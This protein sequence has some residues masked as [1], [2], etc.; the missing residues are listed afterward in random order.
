MKKIIQKSSIIFSFV[1]ML[2][3]GMLLQSTNQNIQI[4]NAENTIPIY[5]VY[6]PNSGEHLHTMNWNEKVALVESGWQYEGISMRVG[7]SGQNLY[8]LYNPNSGEHLYT[9][10]W[11]E[12]ENLASKGWKYEGVAWHTPWTGEPVYRAYNPNARNAGTHHYTVSQAEILS[13]SKAGWKNEGIVWYSYGGTVAATPTQKILN[14]PYVSQYVNPK[15]PWGCAAASMTML[16]RYTGK[17]VDV[18]YAQDNLPMYPGVPDGQ[19]GNV[20]NGVGFGWVIKPSGLARYARNWNPNVVEVTGISV[21][22]IKEK[23]DADKPVLYYGYSSYDVSAR[24]HIKVIV[25][26]NDNGFYIYDPLYYSETGGAMTRG[27][28]KYDRG[29]KA[30]VSYAEFKSEWEGKAISLA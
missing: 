23:I 25:G 15:A 4:V 19:K 27:R 14:V 28:N 29:A 16:L 3:S 1:I 9:L 18:K 11:N 24:N 6:N 17:S 7:V 20:Y 12:K 2:L 30:W 13:L 26:Y 21:Q 10:N 22:G 8:R 5:R